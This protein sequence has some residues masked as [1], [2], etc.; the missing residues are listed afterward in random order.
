MKITDTHKKILRHIK[1]NP[2]ATLK[3]LGIASGIGAT[4]T[5]DYHR[6]ALMAAG[7]LRVTY[8][9]EVIDTNQTRT[10]VGKE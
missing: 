6:K 10:P 3:E 2:Q 7:L 9:W 4:S 1:K 8:A 5:V